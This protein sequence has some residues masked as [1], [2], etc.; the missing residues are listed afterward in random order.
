MCLVKEPTTAAAHLL[1][2]SVITMTALPPS[3]ISG[4]IGYNLPV[5]LGLVLKE[6]AI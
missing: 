2:P 4:N 3:G 1:C 6:V 5:I